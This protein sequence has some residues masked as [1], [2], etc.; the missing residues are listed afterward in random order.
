M[1]ILVTTGLYLLFVL[2]CYNMIGAIGASLK[3]VALVLEVLRNPFGD[4]LEFLLEEL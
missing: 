3:C 1:F 4:I 2:Q